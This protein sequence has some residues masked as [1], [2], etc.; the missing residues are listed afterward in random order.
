MY[1]PPI[2]VKGRLLTPAASSRG[3]GQS[4]HASS[5]CL[6]ATA[7]SRACGGRLA[8]WP[9]IH[10]VWS[11]CLFEAEG[12]RAYHPEPSRC[13]VSK[14]FVSPG[15]SLDLSVLGCDKELSRMLSE[16]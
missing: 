4:T 16:T 3:T 9:C 5:H 6:G 2:T 15:S 10:M 14:N 12:D 11:T 7:G 1:W 8:A 13:P